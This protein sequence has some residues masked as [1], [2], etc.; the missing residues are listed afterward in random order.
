MR[1]KHGA[2]LLDKKISNGFEHSFSCKFLADTF[3][4][5]VFPGSACRLLP[6]GVRA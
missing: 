6:A 1:Q 3:T 5:S 2:V 4:D